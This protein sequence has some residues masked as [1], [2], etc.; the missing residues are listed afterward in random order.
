MN[1]VKSKNALFVLISGLCLIWV[2]PANAQKL[3]SR[4]WLSLSV[5]NASSMLP[6]GGDLFLSSSVVHPG[7]CAGAEFSL[8]HNA[9]NQWLVNARLGYFYHRLSQ[10]AIQLYGEGTYRR[11]LY[12]DRFAIEARLGAGYLHAIPA[13]QVFKQDDDG[14]YRRTGRWGRPQAMLSLGISP[15]YTF[16][17]GSGR[18]FRVF[19]DYQFMI[20]SPFVRS[21]VT[22][23]PYS[24]IHLGVA[25][26]VPSCK[27]N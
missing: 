5:F 13:L 8:K 27:Q 21:Y 1:M 15:T 10:S 6:G 19:L 2:D 20:Q 14:E 7:I 9:A 16:G 18:P 24:L 22:F 11:F 23:L 25:T 12:K 4:P 17:A 26:P 3:N